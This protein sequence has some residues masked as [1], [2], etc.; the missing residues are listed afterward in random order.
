MRSHILREISENKLDP[1][2]AYV[3]GKGKLVEKKKQ[4]ILA[5]SEK[6]A[7]EMKIVEADI[8]SQE[9]VVLSQE[10]NI[11]AAEELPVVTTF[12]EVVDRIDEEVKLATESV[13]EDKKKKSNLSNHSIKSMVTAF[14]I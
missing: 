13:V 11:A 10:V 12:T 4:S 14:L 2:K 7:A 9:E 6:S 8:T 3:L 1:K 5:S